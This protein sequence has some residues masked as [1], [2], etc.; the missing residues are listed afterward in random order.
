MVWLKFFTFLAIA[1][2]GLSAVVPIIDEHFEECVSPS[3]KAGVFDVSG[4][5][6]IAENDTHAYMNGTWKFTRELKAPWLFLLYTERFERDKWN[7][8]AMDKRITDFC[9]VIHNPL[10]AWYSI[11]KDVS[12]C[13][14]KKGVNREFNCMRELF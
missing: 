13:P 8:F 11:Y 3:E 4:L 10:E 14:M 12:G 6:I 1:A 7:L 2:S 5:Q 9:A